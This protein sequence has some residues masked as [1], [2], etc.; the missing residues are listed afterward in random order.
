M[1]ALPISQLPAAA[2]LAGS[3]ILPAVQSGATVRTTAAELRAGLALSTHTH[4]P[5]DV[6]GL[7]AAL[8]ATRRLGRR[9]LWLPAGAMASPAAGGAAAGSVET[10]PHGVVLRS[11]DFAPD[12]ESSAQILLALPRAWDGGA[13]AV[14][15][16]W[17]AGGGSGDVL[18][19]AAGAAL[20]DGDGLDA[21]GGAPVTVADTLDAADALHAAGESAPLPL[22]G[23][24][25]PGGLVL[26]RVARLGGDPADTLDADA[27]LLGLRLLYTVD[28]AS[29]D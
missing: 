17:T 28:A 8:A 23:V 26:L 19:A 21:A 7:P 29:D 13:L 20:G 15:P 11:L 27:R 25:E 14:Q 12:A 10:A 6:A 2:P 16:L 1:P 22:A 24:A 4:A 5:A 18:W 9:S 3:E